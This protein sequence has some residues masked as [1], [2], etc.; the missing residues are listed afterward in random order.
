MNDKKPKKPTEPK[1]RWLKH[2]FW[3]RNLPMASADGKNL[4]DALAKRADSDGR[5]IFPSIET[6][7]KDTGLDEGTVRRQL[8]RLL[9]F[10]IETDDEMR[11]RYIGA[12]KA[13]NLN[14]TIAPNRL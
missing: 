8:A 10:W 13:E 2:L 9:T 11:V 6:M 14:C 5:N 4:L 12:W 3:V 7:A 1:S